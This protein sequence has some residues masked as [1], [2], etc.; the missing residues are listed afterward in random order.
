MSDIDILKRFIVEQNE[1]LAQKIALKIDD[2]MSEVSENKKH[3]EKLE[4]DVVDL[5]NKNIS[6]EMKIRENN[7]LIFNSEYNESEN[8]MQFTINLFHNHLNVLINEYDI[9]N[10]YSFKSAGNP[11]IFVK[12]SRTITKQNI[13]KNCKKLKGK[14]IFIT[15]DLTPTE[16]DHQKVLVQYLKKARSNNYKAHIFRSTL[17]INGQK[18][19]YNDII[20]GNVPT[21]LTISHS[22]DLVQDD[23]TFAESSQKRGPSSP[24]DKNLE[25]ANTKLLRSGSSSS[26]NGDRQLRSGK[27][28]LIA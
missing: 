17:F 15:E 19:K 26:I 20:Q 22:Q 24:A 14:K 4:Q 7:V 11:I 27:N 16:K 21:E 23:D 5:K 3:V 28:K 8:V 1:I 2:V 13:L 9:G 25:A 12:F 10:V 6:L 18:Y